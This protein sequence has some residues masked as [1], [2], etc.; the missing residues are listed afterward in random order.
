M[1]LIVL[2][3]PACEARR[4][5]ACVLRVT[6]LER[7]TDAQLAVLVGR[8]VV[9]VSVG[10]VPAQPL[11]HCFGSFSSM[12]WVVV[13]VTVVILDA[14]GF[15][16]SALHGRCV[17]GW[18]NTCLSTSM[19]LNVVV[20]NDTKPCAAPSPASSLSPSRYVR[21]LRSASTIAAAATT[22]ST[23]TS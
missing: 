9:V 16:C 20:L 12:D 15:L 22:T 7:C 18:S 23:S 2:A 21:F 19:P 13:V 17:C 10:F 1:C 8:C 11:S 4:G 3:G 6:L 5:A 14:G